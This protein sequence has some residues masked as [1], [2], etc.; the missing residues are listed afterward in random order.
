LE[1]FNDATFEL[2][3]VYTT[4][5]R[6]QNNLLNNFMILISNILNI[7]KNDQGFDI[8]NW[9]V[10]EF[11]I[12]SKFQKKK[13]KKKKNQNQDQNNIYIYIHIHMYYNLNSF[14]IYMNN[15]F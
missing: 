10:D 4:Q 14:N 2:K 9:D 11:D 12:E 8:S 1:H 13:K 7:G 15:Y 5:F 6:Q 3:S